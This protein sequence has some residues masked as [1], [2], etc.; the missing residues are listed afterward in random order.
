MVQFTL[1]PPQ[2]SVLMALLE[3]GIQINQSHPL[4]ESFAELREDLVLQVGRSIA[5]RKA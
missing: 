2:Y 5:G 4:L 3:D 1:S